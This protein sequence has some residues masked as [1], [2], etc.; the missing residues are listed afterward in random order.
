MNGPV[1]LVIMKK[2]P[3]IPVMWISLLAFM[4]YLFVDAFNTS[5]IGY[6]AMP[7]G[8]FFGKSFVLEIECS[9]GVNVVW[10]GA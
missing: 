3:F 4:T 9:D 7:I 8:F 10:G 1:L 2:H 5:T 6:A